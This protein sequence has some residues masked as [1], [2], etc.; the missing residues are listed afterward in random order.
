VR[1]GPYRG[2]TKLKEVRERLKQAGI[3]SVVVRLK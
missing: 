2:V 3:D 1:V